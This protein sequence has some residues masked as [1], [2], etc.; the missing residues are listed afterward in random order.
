MEYLYGNSLYLNQLYLQLLQLFEVQFV[1]HILFLSQ[2]QNLH[3]L[4]CQQN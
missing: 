4:K 1:L 3:T 2:L